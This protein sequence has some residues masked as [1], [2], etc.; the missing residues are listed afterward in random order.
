MP[1]AFNREAAPFPEPSQQNF[2]HISWTRS[3]SHGPSCRKSRK[4]K[5]WFLNLSSGGR[6]NGIGVGVG[7]F[8]PVPTHQMSDRVLGLLSPNS[9]SRPGCVL[10]PSKMGTELPEWTRVGW[11]LGSCL[12]GLEGGILG[13]ESPSYRLTLYWKSGHIQC[14]RLCLVLHECPCERRE[15]EFK[16]YMASMWQSQDSNMCCVKTK[17]RL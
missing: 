12:G 5:M 14:A 9:L 17:P 7:Y 4:E 13:R 2:A 16:C 6:Q 3:V 11:R 10:C 8:S 15:R 1:V